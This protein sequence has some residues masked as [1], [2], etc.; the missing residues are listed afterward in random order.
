[1]G[2]DEILLTDVSFPTEGKLNKIA[3]PGAGMQESIRAF[4]MAMD[5]AL[6]AYPDV[7]L[8][9]ELPESV[10]TLGQDETA[11][12]VLSE[13]APLVDRIYTETTEG[14][15][16]ALEAAVEAAG[17]DTALIPELTAIPAESDQPYLLTEP[18]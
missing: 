7:K 2:F 11:G 17:E 12:L 13:I 9:V 5:T 1:M 3:Y 16:P 4:L 18:S 6:A 15:I 8:S 10:I 14:S